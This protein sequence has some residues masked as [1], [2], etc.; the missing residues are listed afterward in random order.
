MNSGRIGPSPYVRSAH[1]E[2]GKGIMKT[3]ESPIDRVIRVILGAVLLYLA[4]GVFAGVLT[5]IF[6]VLG[7]IFV[8]TG[9][10]GFCPLYALLHLNTNKAK[11]R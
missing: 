1:R 3:N 7:A 2:K 10:V 6:A 11:A 9:V 4:F 8:L 5:V